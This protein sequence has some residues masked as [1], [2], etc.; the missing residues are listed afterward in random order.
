MATADSQHRLRVPTFTKKQLVI[1]G[2]FGS[3]KSE[4]AV[5]LAAYLRSISPDPVAIA[6]LDI[7]N[8]YFRSRQAAE[9]LRE[10][11]IEPIN[12]SGSQAHADL[13]IVLP[14]IKGAIRRKDGWL[15]L[16]V[17]GD[18]DGARLLSSMVDAFQENGYD[19]LLV[20]NANR[21]FTADLAG[22]RK[23]IN[24][25]EAASRL[26]FTG[27]ISN[28]HL[29]DSTTPQTIIDGLTLAREVSDDTGLPI[30]MVTAERKIMAQMTDDELGVPVLELDRM[31]L[32]PWE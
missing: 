6:D 19:M 3:G 28:T 4:V 27:I 20:L 13:P 9:Q 1:V 26:R 30:V 31:L 15:V 17:G 21:P 8:P 23:M 24:E 5:N 25:I 16:D 22:C 18:D 14:E 10:L 29:M 12:P 2:G 7:I 32:K 11:G